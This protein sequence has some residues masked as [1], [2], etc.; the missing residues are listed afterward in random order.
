M[1]WHLKQPLAPLVS[2][3]HCVSSAANDI[4]A[5]ER[6]RAYLEKHLKYLPHVQWKDGEPQMFLKE[7]HRAV[8][9]CVTPDKNFL[10]TSRYLVQKVASFRFKDQSL[11]AFFAKVFEFL[12]QV[13]HPLSIEF[14]EKKYINPWHLYIPYDRYYD[15]KRVRWERFTGLHIAAEYDYE[16][17]FEFL[18]KDKNFPFYVQRAARPGGCETPLYSATYED[19]K[20]VFVRIVEYLGLTQGERAR[21]RLLEYI[22]KSVE[23]RP[24]SVMQNVIRRCDIKIWKYL[25]EK[26]GREAINHYIS[27]G[28]L[29]SSLRVQYSKPSTT[30]HR[31]AY[32]NVRRVREFLEYLFAQKDLKLKEEKKENLRTLRIFMR[33]LFAEQPYDALLFLVLGSPEKQLIARFLTTNEQYRQ[34]CEDSE[35]LM[36]ALQRATAHEI[37]YNDEVL[38]LFFESLALDQQHAF[39]RFYAEEKNVGLKIMPQDKTR[40][41]VLRY[42]ERVEEVNA[43]L[44]RYLDAKLEQLELEALTAEAAPILKRVP[45]RL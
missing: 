3:E 1:K 8:L 37:N 38:G 9:A 15:H 43:R 19:G 36:Y 34:Q 13:H 12:C 40:L 20:E 7:F 11:P 42:E 4:E 27:C 23:E 25:E 30:L 16:E 10:E 6:V 29:K 33:D 35:F 45:N 18:Q 26:L 17:L 31:E 44:K 28:L 24:N 39:L 21:E 22:N 41:S 5:L 32:S 14:I 2:L